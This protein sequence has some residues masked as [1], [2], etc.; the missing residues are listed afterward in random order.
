MN[1]SRSGLMKC[2]D[3]MRLLHVLSV[4]SRLWSGCN[5][6]DKGSD[7]GGFIVEWS[8]SVRLPPALCSGVCER[9]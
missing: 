1:V 6:F 5:D 4:E 9:G 7:I 3:G 2:W 8:C